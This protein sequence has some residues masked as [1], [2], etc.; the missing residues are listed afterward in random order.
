MSSKIIFIIFISI[1]LSC[2]NK[3]RDDIKSVP[4]NDIVGDFDRAK[5]PLI[6]K[7]IELSFDGKNEEAIVKF[8][9]AENEYGQSIAISLNR[10]IAYKELKELDLAVE[11]YTQ[12]LKMNP[13]YYP[14]LINR[15]IANGHLENF[16]EAIEDLN[17]A[18][19]LK[20]E[21]PIGYINRAVLNSMRDNKE[22]ACEDIIVAKQLDLNEEYGVGIK[23]LQSE[24]CNNTF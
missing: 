17:N 10:G 11:N 20:P 12:C 6:Q 24:N 16:D 2:Q 1:V 18:I 19:K 7:A 13:N 14:A 3:N 22:L 23:E 15:G 5:Y 4:N 21:H 9:E 8:N